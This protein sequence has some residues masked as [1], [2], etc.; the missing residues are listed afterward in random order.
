M[1]PQR[2]KSQIS[3]NPFCSKCGQNNSGK[4]R[5]RAERDRQR[6]SLNPSFVNYHARGIRVTANKFFSFGRADFGSICVFCSR[7]KCWQRASS[8]QTNVVRQK[9][10]S[11]FKKLKI[12]Y[13]PTSA[14]KKTAHSIKSYQI[15]HCRFTD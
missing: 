2:K 14:K 13:Q 8:C 3:L 9:R 5:Q 4:H 11:V 10:V 7:T 15:L 12:S 6:V 1:S